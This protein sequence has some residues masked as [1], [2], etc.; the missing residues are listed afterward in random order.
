MDSELH[1]YYED[2][3][4]SRA[5]CPNVEY[6]HASGRC[7]Y[8]PSTGHYWHTKSL[9]SYFMFVDEQGLPSK[10]LHVFSTR[11]LIEAV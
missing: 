3:S 8:N 10:H 9:R 7:T 2:E 1:R 11:I 4:K 6:P 5:T